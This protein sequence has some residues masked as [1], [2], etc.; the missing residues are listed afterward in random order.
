MPMKRSPFVAL[1]AI[2]TLTVG[3]AVTAPAFAVAG[4]PA[5]ANGQVILD[6]GSWWRCSQAYKTSVKRAGDKLEDCKRDWFVT[7]SPPVAAG[8]E[9]PDFD[10]ASWARFR[11][12][13]KRAAEVDWGFWQFSAMPPTVSRQALR[14]KFRVEDPAAAKDLKLSLAYRGGVVVYLNGKEIARGHL[15]KGA[16]GADALAEDY[17]PEAFEK[18]EGGP[19]RTSFHEP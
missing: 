5:A 14:G 9:Q 11:L 13:R 6:E 1:G 4:E 10:D 18:P 8:W 3:G 19:I 16:L 17:P 12:A 7:S 2:L 15:P